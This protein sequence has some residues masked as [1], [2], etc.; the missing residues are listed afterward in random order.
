[1]F[2]LPF[3]LNRQQELLINQRLAEF[4]ALHI[5]DNAAWFSELCFCLLTANS[6]A[7]K[8][9]NIQKEIGTEG[10][11][12]Y[13]LQEITNI[14]YAHRHRFHNNKARF[15]VAARAYSN[16]KDLLENMTTMQAREF[17]VTHIKGLGYKEA[18]HFLRN[19][20]YHDCAII[21]R[22]ILRFLAQNKLIDH[23]PKTI[24][25]KI[26]LIFENILTQFKMPL[27]RLDLMIWC[28]M[29]NTV[30]K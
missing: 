13:S 22:H 21:D 7:Q 25:P 12:K 26:Y 11:L 24:T 20:G 9:I 10:F 8:A 23:V 16:I 27:D 4:E 18:S 6:Q 29:T 1:M 30:L 17:L 19:V 2:K 28:H 3:Q 15:I 14:I 5:A